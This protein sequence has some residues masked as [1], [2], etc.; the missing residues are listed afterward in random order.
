MSRRWLVV[1]LLAL[2]CLPALAGRQDPLTSDEVDQMREV[3]QDGPKRLKLLLTF[4]KARMMAIQ[5]IR[6]DPK[7][8]EGRGAR[9]HDLIEDFAAIVVELDRNI[10]QYAG[11][12]QDIRKPLKE[13]IEA[14]ADFQLKLRG[15][16]EAAAQPENA[17]EAKEWRYVLEDAFD[18]VG[19]NGDNARATLDEQNQLAKDKKLVK[20]SY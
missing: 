1:L 12:R 9:I 8:A 16:K 13:V 6:S 20:P 11:M 14:N 10:D 15:L 18:A 5:E 4:A 19:S 17:A 3:S 7:F 2:L